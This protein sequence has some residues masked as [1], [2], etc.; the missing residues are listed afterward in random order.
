[1]GR[2]QGNKARTRQPEME[3]LEVTAQPKSLPEELEANIVQEPGLSVDP[4]DLGRQFLSEATEQRNYESAR[5]GEA[6]ELWAN[7]APPSDEPLAGPNFDAD[8]SVWERTISVSM[9]NGG[10][11]GAQN[12][13]SPSLTSDEE[14]EDA[15]DDGLHASGHDDDVDLT[16]SSIHD[17]SLLDHEGEE[18]GETEAPRVQ[19]DDTHSHAKRRGGHAPKGARSPQRAR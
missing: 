14:D 7:S 3:E 9:E 15:D 13:L 2:Q 5:G 19:T 17:G 4:E 12:A 10:P 6:T 11:E 8:R 1:M 18:L 16:E